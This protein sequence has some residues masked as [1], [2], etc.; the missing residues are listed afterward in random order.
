ADDESGP[1]IRWALD[2]HR[3]GALADADGHGAE[4]AAVQH[5]VGRT[6]PPARA[7]PALRG[8]PGLGAA[9]VLPTG[10][11]AVAAV[12]VGREELPGQT[13]VDEEERVVAQPE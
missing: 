8:R 2:Q 12:L 13:V 3:G 9:V 1:G 7:V 6:R 4:R 5:R 11:G 10:H